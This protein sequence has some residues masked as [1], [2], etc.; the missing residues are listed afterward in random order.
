MITTTEEFGG[1]MS[2]NSLHLRSVK[3]NNFASSSIY[4]T[5]LVLTYKAQF[6]LK[7]FNT[8]VFSKYRYAFKAN[9]LN[10]ESL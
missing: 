7:C 2:N 10:S 6:N 4:Y 5:S 1:R 9:Y 8:D 3:E